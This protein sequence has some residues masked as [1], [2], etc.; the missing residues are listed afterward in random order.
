MVSENKNDKNLDQSNKSKG[1][2][3]FNSIVSDE[4]V[5]ASKI[6]EN[7]YYVKAEP[8]YK[9][10]I[11]GDYVSTSKCNLDHFSFLVSDIHKQVILIFNDNTKTWRDRI[12]G[13]ANNG[14]KIQRMKNE[15]ESQFLFDFPQYSRYELIYDCFVIFPD[16]VVGDYQNPELEEK[17]IDD[18]CVSINYETGTLSTYDDCWLLDGGFRLGQFLKC[19]GELNEDINNGIKLSKA[20]I[21]DKWKEIYSN[22]RYKPARALTKEA[23]FKD[24][25]HAK[26]SL[27]H[28]NNEYSIED[29]KD[30]LIELNIQHHKNISMKNGI[31]LL[32]DF[33]NK[34]NQNL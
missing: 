5:N 34:E 26:Y 8:K 1:G 18:G 20:S 27:I 32:I 23:I 4:M 12:Y 19:L 16:S 28:K 15:I 9:K 22:F 29:V 14:T 33:L 2:A 11:C 21:R 31:E 3:E 30:L 6:L 7:F 10:K 25:E 13:K 17:Y 24:L